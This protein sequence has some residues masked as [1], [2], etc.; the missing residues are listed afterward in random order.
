MFDGGLDPMVSPGEGRDGVVWGDDGFDDTVYWITEL[1]L[2]D[3]WVADDRDSLPDIESIPPG[4]FL[5]VILSSVDRCKLN[6]YDLVRVLKARERL[7]SHHQAQSAADMMEISYSAPGDSKSPARRIEE[8]A[9]YASDEIRA[10]L[11]LTRRSADTRL[12]DATDLR[13]RLPQAWQLLDQGLIDWPK[14]R[15]ITD[16]TCHL[17]ETEA[18]NIVSQVAGLAP[19]LTTGQLRARIRRLC[20]DTNP[21]QARQRYEHAVEARKLWIEPT[22]D[23]TANLHLYHIPITTAKAE[24]R[25]V[26]THMISLNKEDRTGR[27][28]DQLRADITCDLLLGADPTHRGR[29]LVDIKVDLT[30]LACLDDHASEIPGQSSPT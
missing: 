5:A 30:T 21:E 20:V 4:P 10:A 22:V 1:E 16:G 29:G 3:G 6:G 17:T 27:T 25:R 9:E 18:R 8:A 28:H 15:V 11:H 12:G 2:A 24:G 7:V 14:A 23:G 13:E 26:N 19:H